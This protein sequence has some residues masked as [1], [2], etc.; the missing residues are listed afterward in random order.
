MLGGVN[1]NY[2][3]VLLVTGSVLLAAIYHTI[4]YWHRST[5]L[6]GSYSAYLWASFLYCGFRTLFFSYYGPVYAYFNPDELLQMIAFAF[7]VRFVAVA[8]HPVSYT[9]LTLPTNREV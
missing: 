5:S 2:I 6:L 9:H 8:L 3:I 4:L 7:Y 1:V